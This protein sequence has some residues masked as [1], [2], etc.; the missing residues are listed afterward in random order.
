MI[1]LPETKLEWIAV[2]VENGYKHNSHGEL[3]DQIARLWVKY[4]NELDP[5]LELGE[6]YF[7]K[8]PDN[9]IDTL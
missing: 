5:E 7:L 1:Y 8:E 4:F 6:D 3:D 2:L 9:G